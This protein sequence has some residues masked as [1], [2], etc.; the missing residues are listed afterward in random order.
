[1]MSLQNTYFANRTNGFN[2]NIEGVNIILQYC[3]IYFVLKNFD[4]N[5]FYLK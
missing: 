2:E 4:E 3:K 1:M 5:I